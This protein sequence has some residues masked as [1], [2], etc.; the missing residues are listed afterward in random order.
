[1]LMLCNKGEILGRAY[2]R[3]RASFE[4]ARDEGL[5]ENV[6]LQR[7]L[8]NAARQKIDVHARTCKVCDL[9]AISSAELLDVDV[10]QVLASRLKM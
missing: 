1:M 4:S 2:M 7:H 5:N 10:E 3:S 6:S 9:R 8:M